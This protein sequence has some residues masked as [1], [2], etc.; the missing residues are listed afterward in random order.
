MDWA[1][2]LKSSAIV[3]PRRRICCRFFRACNALSPSAASSSSSSS[4]L[5]QFVNR[6]KVGRRLPPAVISGGVAWL[7]LSKFAE[8]AP[9][10]SGNR[11]GG[12][13]EQFAQNKRH[14][15]A[16]TGGQ[17]EK[18]WPLQVIGNKVVKSLLLLRSGRIPARWPC[19]WCRGRIRAP[20]GARCAGRSASTA[21]S[22]RRNLLGWS[23]LE[24]WDLKAFQIAEGIVVNDTDQTE[25]FQEGVLQR[26]SR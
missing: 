8:P 2:D 4:T 24:N 1:S 21:P 25:E 14:Q 10:G 16:L 26:A 18:R 7:R 3:A 11:V 17:G 22:G 13:R 6:L 12:R 19:G 5:P 9:Q 23:R 20:A 15:L